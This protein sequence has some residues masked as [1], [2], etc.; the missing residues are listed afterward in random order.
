MFVGDGPVFWK[1]KRQ[2]VVMP[3]S[4]EAEF[5]NLTP[6]V[7]SLLWISEIMR[8]MGYEG[9]TPAVMYT[10]SQNARLHVLASNPARTRHIDLRYR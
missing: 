8:E 4:T 1:S 10:H 9:K 2:T 7:K 3:S 5:I 6:A